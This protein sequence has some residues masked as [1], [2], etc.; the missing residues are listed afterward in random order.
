MLGF[1][2]HFLPLFLFRHPFPFLAS[3]QSTLFF[4]SYEI[5]VVGRLDILI[6]FL[7][8][9]RTRF[10]IFIIFCQSHLLLANP[11][12]RYVSTKIN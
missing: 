8:T 7:R 4:S 9:K 3:F 6:S 2:F 12:T 1:L 10:F 11:S 5:E